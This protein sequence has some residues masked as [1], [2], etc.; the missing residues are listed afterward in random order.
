MARLL[1]TGS[2]QLF[3]G[4]AG[5]VV[6]DGDRAEGPK[7]MCIG[8]NKIV[9]K[10]RK[11]HSKGARIGTKAFVSGNHSRRAVT[12]MLLIIDVSGGSD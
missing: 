11:D 8:R 10:R 7:S 2:Q 12:L 1:F 4:R 6:S 9:A 3:D 5:E